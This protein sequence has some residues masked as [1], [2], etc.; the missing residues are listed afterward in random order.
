M[1]APRLQNSAPGG[2]GGAEA[3][4]ANKEG[5]R[6]GTTTLGDDNGVRRRVEQ[7]RESGRCAGPLATGDSIKSREGRQ[8]GR[9]ARSPP[10]TGPRRPARWP[11]PR[12]PARRTGR[13]RVALGSA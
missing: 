5:V 6:A 9:W 2:A 11:P 3:A 1:T 8:D 7:R 10:L 4:A 12:G 13:E